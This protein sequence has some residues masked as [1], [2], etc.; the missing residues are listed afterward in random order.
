[1]IEINRVYVYG[2][3]YHYDVVI[4]GQMV[5]RYER[6]YQAEES[7]AEYAAMMETKQ[8]TM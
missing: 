7:A 8:W 4:N 6:K 5:E 3:G 2:Y 1:M